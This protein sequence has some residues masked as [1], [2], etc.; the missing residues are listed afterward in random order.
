M[1]G[2]VESHRFLYRVHIPRKSLQLQTCKK[3]ESGEKERKRENV[4]EERW[5]A[6]TDTV[7]SCV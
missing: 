1:R 3:T 5:T 2:F 6:V 4:E 7:F